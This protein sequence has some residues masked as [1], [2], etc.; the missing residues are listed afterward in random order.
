[1]KNR[2]RAINHVKAKKHHVC[3]RQS[4]AC[5]SQLD[6][7]SDRRLSNSSSLSHQS[8]R[9]PDWQQ[10]IKQPNDYFQSLCRLNYQSNMLMTSTMSISVNVFIYLFSV[11]FKPCFYFLYFISFFKLLRC[12]LHWQL[13]RIQTINRC[14]SSVMR[15]RP[16]FSRGCYKQLLEIHT[17]N[18][19][20]MN[21]YVSL[22]GG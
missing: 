7:E 13:K 18:T 19:D 4:S 12:V 11:I 9:K 1:M 17:V 15:A 14:E 22:Q 10:Q 16:S 3:D 8:R 21:Q 20:Y 6:S 5:S 2:S